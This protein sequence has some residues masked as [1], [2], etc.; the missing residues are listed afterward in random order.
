[1]PSNF[2]LPVISED[3]WINNSLRVGEYLFSHFVLSD[4][5]QS[6]V[7]QGGVSSLPYL[8]AT[9]GNNHTELKSKI[10]FVLNI[11]FSKYFN[12]VSVLV[13]IEKLKDLNDAYNLAV[14]IDFVDKEGVN[15][16]LDKSIEL[17]NSKIQKIITINKG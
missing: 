4:F 15:L 10:E 17:V 3:G 2:F 7:Y 14:S 8:I 9:Y 13:Y 12:E 1:M 11:Y 6:Y 5:S 16:S